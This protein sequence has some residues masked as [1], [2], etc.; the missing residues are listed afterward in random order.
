MSNKTDA[1]I[2]CLIK[3]FPDKVNW[4]SIAK[5]RYVSID[6]IEKYILDKTSYR[7]ELMKNYNVFPSNIAKWYGGCKIFMKNDLLQ[8]KENPNLDEHFVR[9]Y[10]SDKCYK[11]GNFLKV[12]TLTTEEFEANW[13]YMDLAEFFRNYHKIDLIEHYLDLIIYYKDGSWCKIFEQNQ[14]WNNIGLNPN[15]TV[16]FLEKYHSYM[17]WKY[18]RWNPNLTKEFIAKYQLKIDW[19]SFICNTNIPYDYIEKYMEFIPKSCYPMIKNLPFS[20][21]SKYP[22]I[23]CWDNPNITVDFIMENVDKVCRDKLSANPSLTIEFIKRYENVLNWDILWQNSF[24]TSTSRIEFNV[25]PTNFNTKSYVNKINESPKQVNNHFDYKTIDD[26]NLIC[27]TDG[28]VK[29]YYKTDIT[30]TIWNFLI[31]DQFKVIKTIDG[32]EIT[33]GDIIIRAH[34][35]SYDH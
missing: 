20:V 29:H 2:E 3:E 15:I 32:I 5:N 28:A 1:I 10:F 21:I 23:N 16:D 8:I 27:V 7:L 12:I 35:F 6:F 14:I 34:K 13:Q 11:F 33:N 24:I 31:N 18:I 22:E 4:N 26:I 17:N 19:M 9:W 30:E 25:N